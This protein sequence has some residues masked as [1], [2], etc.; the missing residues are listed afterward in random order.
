MGGAAGIMSCKN[1]K[2]QGKRNIFLRYQKEEI[3]E[4][5]EI[6][7]IEINFFHL[8]QCKHRVTNS[9]LLMLVRIK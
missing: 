8:R 2:L 4:I 7:N 5:I 1:A 3:I 9:N 6:K